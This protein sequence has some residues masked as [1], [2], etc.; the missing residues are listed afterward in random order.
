MGVF[1]MKKWDKPPDEE[2]S[3]EEIKDL[4]DKE[5]KVMVTQKKDRWSQWEI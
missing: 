4:S 2:L 1:K 3:E 5:F